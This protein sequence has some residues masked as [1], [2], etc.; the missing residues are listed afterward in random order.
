MF[1]FNS[2]LSLTAYE[3][4]AN[5]QASSLL[6][7]GTYSV[8]INPEEI[9]TSFEAGKSDEEPVLSAAG[10]P[11]D[12]K[13]AAYSKQRVSISFTIDNTGV[14]PSAPDKASFLPGTSIKKSVDQFLK[15]TTKP[16][17]ATHRPPFVKLQWGGFILV[18]KV[19]NVSIDYTYF[20]SS[21]DPVR[22]TISFTLVEEVDEKVISREFQSPD[23]T[24]IVKVKDGD[25]LI[26]LSDSF[27]DDPKYYLQVA[28]YN[29][30]PSFRGLS[31]GSQLEFPPLEK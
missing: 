14:L 4:F 13:N 1:S 27:Y 18:G 24:R 11:V 10:M 28:E 6:R 26:A 25:S 2:N 7:G 8:Q 12:E 3:K 29:N 21:G 5:G 30:L 23:I 16:T 22:A 17:R 19:F 20:N 15:V 9:K 31:M